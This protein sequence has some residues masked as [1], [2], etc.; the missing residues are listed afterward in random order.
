VKLSLDQARDQLAFTGGVVTDATAR[1]ETA[2]ARAQEAR[3]DYAGDTTD[4][5]WRAVESAEREEKKAAAICESAAS[6]HDAARLAVVAAERA[7]D[8]ARLAEL[9]RATSIAAADASLAPHVEALGAIYPAAH[10]AITAIREI[11][12]EH[13]KGEA[14]LSAVAA[15]LETTVSARP[16]LTAGRAH[17]FLLR[18]ISRA[19]AA[20]G[21]PAVPGDLRLAAPVT[22]PRPIPDEQDLAL[23]IAKLCGTQIDNAA[24]SVRGGDRRRRVQTMSAVEQAEMIVAGRDHHAEIAARRVQEKV[25]DAGWIASAAAEARAGLATILGPKEIEA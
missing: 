19:A 15:R 9:L 7:A 5:R 1:L 22:L 11:V 2:Q 14:E 4:A 12:A 10:R 21:M 16:T 13:A 23:E 3:R 20:S 8:E 6:A 17:A 24:C 25:D 18:A